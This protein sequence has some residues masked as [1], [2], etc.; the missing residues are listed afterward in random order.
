MSTTETFEI[1]L[2][3]AEA[4][5]ST[6]VPAIFA[7]WAPLLVDAAGV[8]PG[9]AVLDVA[10]GTGIV[11]RT[12]A[13]RLDGDGV[14]VGLDRNEAML[15]VA[16][17]VSPEL[18]WQLG[19]AATLPFPD[20]SY[21]VALCQMALMFF[22]DRVHA[23]RE[24]RRVVAAEGT[25]GVVVPASLPEQPAYAP[26]VEM[27][28]RHSAEAR[29]YLSTYWAAGA[30]DQLC[31]EFAAAGLDVVDTLTHRGT[32]RFAS[33]E[34]FVTTEVEG[35]PLI[36]RISAETYQA[37]RRDAHDVLAPFLAEG[38]LRAPLVGHL[39]VGRPAG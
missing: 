38:G 16:R 31:G 30:L 23:L 26:F 20:R 22:P 6:F 2:T 25:V 11:A 3:A 18:A 8:R 39:V 21:D 36:N 7:E 10:C 1:S 27:A 35:T 24:M 29:T 13:D 28:A 33:V 19:D 15:T 5:E 14:V 12:A 17:R 4:Y 9:Q 34:Q 32:A 37:I